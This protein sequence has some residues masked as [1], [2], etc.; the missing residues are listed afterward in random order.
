MLLP[1]FPNATQQQLN[2][3]QHNN[4]FDLDALLNPM[5]HIQETGTSSSTL[6]PQRTSNPPQMRFFAQK[7][8]RYGSVV[9]FLRPNYPNGIQLRELWKTISAGGRSQDEDPDIRHDLL[10]VADSW[11]GRA[12]GRL[13]AI[14][15]SAVVHFEGLM[16]KG[17]KGGLHYGIKFADKD[18]FYTH[19]RP[20]REWIEESA[21]F[22]PASFL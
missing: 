2:Q 22:T 19:E 3:Q 8:V 13:I 4:F 12:R 14:E 18:P 6:L 20:Q 1:K 16:V 17:K 9:K 21:K 11:S 15:M 10:S 7:F 5:P